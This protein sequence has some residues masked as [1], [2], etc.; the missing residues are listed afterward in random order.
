M[1][2]G[3]VASSDPSSSTSSVSSASSASAEGSSRLSGSEKPGL[4]RGAVRAPRRHPPVLRMVLEALQAG[5]RRRGTSV[6]AIKVYILQKYPTVDALRLNHLLKQALATGL[7][8]GLLIRPVNSKAKGATGSFKLVPKDKRKIPP[9][10][11]APRM[12]GQA[13]GKD[14]KKP[15]E[16]KKDPANPGEVKKGSRK[17]REGRAAPSKPG[18]AKKAPKKG[19]Q[20]KDPEPRLGEAKKSS[21]RPDKAAQ[22]PPGASGPGGKSKVKERGSR[23]DTKAHRKTQLGGQSSKSTVTKGENGASLAKKKMGGKVPKEAAGEGP[24]AKAP[25]PPKGSGS[26]KEPAPLAGK[27]EASKG[28]RKPGI[29]TK[30]SVSKAA[31][32]K[33]EAEG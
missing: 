2:P 26:K 22:A 31:S 7:H 25:V 18:A 12:P 19:T 14:P 9:R 32:K 21:R 4:A 16:S 3:S 23:Q 6:A 13:E 28:P 5:E 11:T 29:S 33:A 20:T 1:A 24:K 27:A 30:S 10:K 8:R 17:P 15:S